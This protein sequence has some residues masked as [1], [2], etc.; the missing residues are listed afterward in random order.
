MIA[1]E[2]ITEF[3]SSVG[4]FG[5]DGASGRIQALCDWLSRVESC[6]QSPSGCMSRLLDDFIRRGDFRT[7]LDR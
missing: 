5:I 6:T 4:Q 1:P 3:H 7:W 2:F